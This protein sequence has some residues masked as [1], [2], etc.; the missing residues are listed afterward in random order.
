M[1]NRILT[2]AILIVAQATA[3]LAQTGF[4]QYYYMQKKQPMTVVPVVHVQN[5]KNWYAEARYN[6]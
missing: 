4:E 6:Y 5:C 3:V 1:K 2:I